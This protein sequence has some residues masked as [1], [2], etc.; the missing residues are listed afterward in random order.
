MTQAAVPAPRASLRGI[1][2]IVSVILAGTIYEINITIATVALPHMQGAFAATHDQISWVVTSFVLGMTMVLAC[3]GW[4]A[5]RFGRKRIFLIGTIGFTLASLLCGTATS[6]EEA[7]LWRLLQGGF[8]APLVPISQAMTLDAFPKEHHGTALT[9]WGIATMIGPAM[10]PTVGGLLVEH[11]S[12]PWTFYFGVPF[13]IIAAIGVWLL[14]EED[15]PLASRPMD[16]IGFTA[17]ITVVA[18]LQ[19]ILNR[20]ERLDWFASAEIIVATAVTIAALYI[21]VIHSTL[22]RHPFLE[23]AMFRDRNFAIGLPLTFVWGFVLYGNIVLTSLMLQELRGF[24]VV[25]LGLVMSPRGIGVMVGMVIGNLLITRLNPR[26]ILSMGLGMIALSSWVMS[27]WSNQVEPFAVIWTGFLQGVG[28]GCGFIPL[29]AMMFAT[30]NTKLRTEGIMLFNLML[31]TG[32]SCGIAVAVSVLTRSTSINH[33]T[34]MEHISRYNDL[35]SQPRA[36]GAWDTGTRGGL[37]SIEAEVTRQATM[38]GY[39]NNFTFI[40]YLTLAAVPCAFLFRR[41]R[42]QAPAPGMH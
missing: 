5:D 16:W 14:V 19:F 34:L 21:F 25:T 20:G 2:L 40:A 28:T 27:G 26:I 7:V 4:L 36:A 15:T 22:A 23:P 32:I 6:V 29:F 8:G 31:F 35:L 41:V 37:A 18:M 3:S 13:G 33:A 38:I 17:I 9:I 39:L 1:A 42:D 12:W 10:G 24:P 30:L 11:Y